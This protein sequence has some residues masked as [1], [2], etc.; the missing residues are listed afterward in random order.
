MNSRVDTIQAAKFLTKLEILDE[1]IAAR[2]A[3]TGAYDDAFRNHW[4]RPPT[5]G[6]GG[7]SAWAQYTIPVDERER[8][9]ERLEKVAVPTVVHYPL[10]LNRQPAAADADASD[11]HGLQ[12][13][14]EVLSL[15]MHTH[16]TFHDRQHVVKMLI[17]V[18]DEQD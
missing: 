3:L 15:L 13:A 8:V 14:E 18:T 11:P 5:I 10:A 16:M 2:Q 4:I 12:A 9:L 6:L 17:D 1:Q 7:R